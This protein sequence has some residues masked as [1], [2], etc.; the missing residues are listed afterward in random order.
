LTQ[1]RIS[2]P[3]N[4]EEKTLGIGFRVRN[5]ERA[6]DQEWVE[7]FKELPVA[8]VSDSMHRM[9]AAG[10][11]LRP[12][13]RDGKLAGRALTV[14]APPGDNLMLHKAIDMVEQGDVIVMDA[15]GD[16]T[17]A[18]IG[19]MMLGYARRRGM[20]GLVLNGAI[21]DADAFLEANVPAYAVGVTHRGPYKNG[22]GEVNC[23]IAIGGM[24]VMPGDLVLGDADGVVVVPI[25]DV[26]D[27][28]EKT[29]AKHAAETRQMEA[30]RAGTHKPTWFNEALVKL[31]CE[32]PS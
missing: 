16:V 23:P 8:N 4:Q 11:K 26:A 10:A 13:H 6:V 14:K 32:M 29:V 1:S 21:R 3:P 5:R 17:N 31:G 22:P 9:S 2:T 7:K 30:I 18:L 19:E 12:M 24:V 20:A 15:G 28:Y 27:V 25:D